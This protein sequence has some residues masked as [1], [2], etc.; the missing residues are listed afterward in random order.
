MT[1]TAIN[2]PEYRDVP[3]ALLVPS[4]TN[5]R[6]RFDEAFLRELAASIQANGVLT[7]LLVR[8]KEEHLEIVFGEQR[9]RAA[10]IAEAATIPVRIREMTDAQVLEAQLVELSIVRKSFLSLY[11]TSARRLYVIDVPGLPQTNCW[12]QRNAA[13]QGMRSLMVASVRW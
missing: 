12:I 5:P 8:P 6:R 10:Q 3:L 11:A 2:T 4:T 1:T 9:Y 7:P 13:A